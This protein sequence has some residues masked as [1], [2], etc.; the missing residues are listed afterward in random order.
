MKILS[1]ACG[2]GID[3]GLAQHIDGV[4]KP[5]AYGSR[6]L[7]KLEAN[8]SIMEKE[9]LAL[10]EYDKTIVYRSGKAYDNADCL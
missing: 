7:S 9:C 3:E 10:V 8:Y 6:L 4:E 5:V 2:Y 1:V